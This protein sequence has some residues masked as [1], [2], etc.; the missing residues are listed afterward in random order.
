MARVWGFDIGTTSIG[1][2]AIEHGFTSGTGRILGMGV[3]IFPE[4]RDPDGTPLN[5]SRRQKRMARRQLRRRRERRRALNQMLADT[6]LLPPFSKEKSSDWSRIM[7]LPPLP[8]RARALNERIEL[9]ELGR[10]LYHLAKRRHFRG[11]DLEESY[12]PNVEDAVEKAAGDARERTIADIG[13]TGNTLGQMLAATPQ[14]ERS[15]GVHALRSHVAE[16]FE[17][18]WTAQAKHHPMLSDTLKAHV[19]DIIFAQKPVFWRKSTLGQCPL[20]PGEELAPKGSWLS[21]Q[22][23]MLEKLNNLEIAS[24]NRRPLDAEERAAVLAKLQTQASM[25][26]GGVRSALKPLYAARGETGME[27]RLRFNLELGGEPKLLGNPLEAKLAVVFDDRWATHPHRQAI[28]DA[29]HRRLWSADYDEVGTQR[30]VILPAKE[31]ER[32]RAE[33]T[34]TLTDDFGLSEAETEALA[35]LALPTGWE[36]FSTRALEAILPELERGERFG[37]LMMSPSAQHGA[38]R[39]SPTAKHRPVKCSTVCPAPLGRSCRTDAVTQPRRTGSRQ[40]A[41]LP[42]C[43]RRTSCARSSTT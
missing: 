10:A 38:R 25:T 35:A 41:I 9:H 30:V 18:L 27:K 20:M 3:R 36:P 31:R 21:Q 22:R 43:G 39:P 26:W 37:T 4:A 14:H 1:W 28:R 23:R 32:R 7:A 11:R 42:S 34:R 13:A 33:A 15:R 16:E 40:S 29:I 5:Q 19:A 24:A 2:A 6:G 8:I 17:R 12:V